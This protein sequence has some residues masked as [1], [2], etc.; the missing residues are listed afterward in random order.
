MPVDAQF[1][2]SVEATGDDLEYVWKRIPEEEW[3]DAVDYRKST[4]SISVRDVPG[5]AKFQCIV[6]N[7]FGDVKSNIAKLVRGI[8][9]YQCSFNF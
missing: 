5:P 1:K 7:E 4:L 8:Y 9:V 2:F 6:S 3:P